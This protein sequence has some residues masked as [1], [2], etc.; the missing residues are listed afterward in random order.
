MQRVTH[1]GIAFAQCPL[2]LLDEGSVIFEDGNG[3]P[4]VVAQTLAE[5][6][7]RMSERGLSAEAVVEEKLE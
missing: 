3:P 1:F 4:V 7:L 2:L 6:I 5:F